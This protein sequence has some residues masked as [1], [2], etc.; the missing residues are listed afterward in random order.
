M[1][2]KLVEKFTSEAAIINV[3]YP[4]T[5]VSPPTS[6]EPVRGDYEYRVEEL[7]YLR[8]GDKG[9]TVNIGLKL[10]AYFP[11][12][13]ILVF[14]KAWWHETQRLCHTCANN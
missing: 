2:G 11:C 4:E 10:A 12:I 8:S 13:D 9:D 5:V 14:L 3:Q 6:A 1:N 7:A